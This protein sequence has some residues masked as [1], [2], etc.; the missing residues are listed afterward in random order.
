MKGVSK[1]AI[2]LLAA[3]AGLAGCKS[4]G[5]YVHV[6]ILGAADEPAGIVDIELDTD[7]AGKSNTLH[8]TNPDHSPIQLPTD[9]TLEVK[10]GTGQLALT[11]IGRNAAGAEVDRAVTT[12]TVASGAIVEASIQLPGGKPDLQPAEA[13]H[14]F[15]ALAEGTQGNAVNVTFNNVGFK[16]SGPVTVA[17]GGVGASSW[18]I[19]SNGCTGSIAVAGNCVV[20]LQ[21][22]PLAQG[23]LAATLTAS[24]T[25]G[26]SAVVA[27]TGSGSSN[28]QNLDV[29]VT[30]AGT[31]NAAPSG[32]ACSAGTC[33]HAFDWGTGVTLTATPATGSHFVRW[34]GAC[35]GTSTTCSLTL[36]SPKAVTATFALDQETLT[37]NVAGNGTVNSADSLISCAGAAPCAASYPFGTSVTLTASPGTGFHL[38]AWGTAAC[39][40]ATQPCTFT[41]SAN[42]TVNA[43]FAPNQ[44]ILTV[45]LVGNTGTGSVASSEPSPIIQCA[46]V[47]SSP[48]SGTFC[49][50]K[51]YDFGSPITLT[52]SPASDSDP[53]GF[54]LPPG[55][56]C[57]NGASLTTCDIVMPDGDTTIDVLID[58][59]PVSV[60]LTFS[61]T[62]T[63]AVDDGVTSC[64]N[65]QQPCVFSEAYGSTPTFTATANPS[66]T[67]GTWTGGGCATGTGCTVPALTSDLPLDARFDIR[68]ITLTVSPA[69][70]GSGTV[71]SNETPTP[72]I[73]CTSGNPAGCSAAYTYGST[74]T[75][76]ESPAISSNFTSWAGGGCSGSGT[77]CG[78][79]ALTANTV[80]TPTFTLKKN[81]VTIAGGG[82]GSGTITGGGLNCTITLGTASGT[83]SVN[84]DY[85]TNI[86]LSEGPAASSNFTNWSGGCAG[87]ATTCPINNVTSPKN[88]TAAFALKTFVVTV[89]GAG[90]GSGTITG[91]SLN[92]AISVGAAGGACTTS[93]N[94]GSNLTMTEAPAAGSAFTSWSGGCAGTASTCTIN[95]ITSTPATVTAAIASTMCAAGVN[96]VQTYSASMA[97]CAGAVANANRASLC[98]AGAHV[99]TADEYVEYNGG[100]APG[101][102]YWTDD[103]LNPP[104]GAGT[105]GS[106]PCA[107]NNCFVSMVSDPN[108]TNSCGAGGASMAVCSGTADAEGNGCF[109][110]GCGYTSIAPNQFF[111]G[112]VKTN[113][114]TP[115][116]GVTAGALC[117]AGSS[118]VFYV[119]ASSGADANAGTPAKPF[120][121]ITHALTVAASGQQI[122]V[123]PGFYDASNGE[124]FPLNVPAGVILTGDEVNRGSIT[125][126]TNISGCGTASPVCGGANTAA[127]IAGAGSTIAGFVISCAGGT[128]I[129]ATGSGVTIR[130]NTLTG[131]NVSGAGACFVNS[132]GNDILDLNNINANYVGVWYWAAAGGGKGEN[133]NITSNLYGVIYNSP[134][135]NLGDPAS[136]PASVGN[137]TISCNSQNDL[138]CE[139]QV[140]AN[141]ASNKWDHNPPHMVPTSSP[142]VDVYNPAAN[143]CTFNFGT[144][145]VNP[146]GCV[147]CASNSSTPV[148]SSAQVYNGVMTG[149]GGAVTHA[150]D[151]TLCANGCHV[152]SAAEY[153][154]NNGG[155]RPNRNYWVADTLL[156]NG[157]A[158]S[159]SVSTTTGASCSPGSSMLA[160]FNAPAA[161]ADGNICNWTDCGFNTVTPDQFFGGCAISNSINP[162]LGFTAGA[163]C[164]CT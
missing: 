132:S 15:G 32:L 96:G 104:Q 31:V 79:A 94:Y 163:L 121:T 36:D 52:V 17:L 87:T 95:N 58:H 85:G 109:A 113:S 61:G 7:L 73:N 53:K 102:I 37:V 92:C 97:G 63:G 57:S 117:C 140:T 33:S 69:G 54:T 119:N 103:I 8:F 62:G 139:A 164:C 146:N 22:R 46:A 159:C 29:S 38:S 134:G 147:G 10:S 41:M 124:T 122:R 27:L 135:G 83:C 64:N 157:T 18:G 56:S 99:C 144:S 77:G 35:S 116:S 40:D 59:K 3:C 34:T 9:M 84:V 88:V 68:M 131:N 55:L 141:V 47:T 130:N 128:G 158:S 67:F 6:R 51:Q 23:A 20:S 5:T 137:N 49:D 24:A 86:T 148:A 28:P 70:N 152:C 60:T 75:L 156:Y 65:A 80:V 162:S 133:N 30:G 145:R 72:K 153:V 114:I 11:A 149:C 25:P 39:A 82:N 118:N 106:T 93:V 74:P 129:L 127:V 14:D 101:H 81:S 19:V 71:T 160:C 26:G 112:C 110:T 91:G 107:A 105:C 161:D 136:P 66:S 2:A 125:S 44:H 111:G 155:T 21:F 100:T 120:K 154:A 45:Q 13:A 4:K 138:Y 90:N 115:A 143:S 142:G 43:V 123:A 12:V 48:G 1:T 108:Y 42:T 50:S 150:N 76:T 78:V 98:A 16:P 126:S 151:A 89:A